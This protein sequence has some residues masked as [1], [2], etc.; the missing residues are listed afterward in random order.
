[1]VVTSCNSKIREIS[2]KLGLRQQN[3]AANRSGFSHCQ[4][5]EAAEGQAE[6]DLSKALEGAQVRRLSEWK[7]IVGP[8]AHVKSY[9]LESV[10]GTW[11]HLETNKKSTHIFSNGWICLWCCCFSCFLLGHFFKHPYFWKQTCAQQF[12]I[13]VCGGLWDPTKTQPTWLSTGT[14]CNVFAIH[15]IY[16]MDVRF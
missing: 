12:H 2:Q 3:M 9:G 7:T 11:N 10:N 13:D 6:E 8:W 14:A 4:A 5:Q 16:I 1:M 15:I